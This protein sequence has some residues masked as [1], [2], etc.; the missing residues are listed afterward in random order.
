[1][2]CLIHF[3]LTFYTTLIPNFYFQFWKLVCIIRMARICLQFNI[4]QSTINNS[5]LP[6]QLTFNKSHGKSNYDI[7]QNQQRFFLDAKIQFYQYTRTFISYRCFSVISESW[8]SLV[9][10]IIK[11]L[12]VK[13]P[14]IYITTIKCYE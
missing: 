7:P 3:F 5:G 10:E 11:I 1:M 8:R 12:K 9:I 4:I 13:N 6:L 14:W 2:K